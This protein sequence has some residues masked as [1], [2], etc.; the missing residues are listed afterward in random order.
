MELEV[1]C[2]YELISIDGTRWVVRVTDENTI[3][4]VIEV[5]EEND[6]KVDVYTGTIM[7]GGNLLQKGTVTLLNR[8]VH[9]ERKK[10]RTSTEKQVDDLIEHVQRQFRM[11][12]LWEQ[13]NETLD[14]GNY[15]V[16]IELSK[17]YAK[18]KRKVTS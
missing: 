16:F 14:S 10:R 6:K 13:I 11:N 2:T 17:E 1:G 12:Q 5:L 7:K 9:A 18:L 8:E 15:E 4:Y 3:K